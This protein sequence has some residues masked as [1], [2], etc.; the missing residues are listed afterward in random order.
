MTAEKYEGLGS[1]GSNPYQPKTRP[2]INFHGRTFIYDLKSP[3]GY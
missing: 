3:M 1:D 2:Y